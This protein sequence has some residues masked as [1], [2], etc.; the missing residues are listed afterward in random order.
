MGTSRFSR[1]PCC[2]D[3]KKFFKVIGSHS[4]FVMFS[5][6]AIKHRWLC[7]NT[8][9]V[10]QAKPLAM[11]LPLSAKTGMTHVAHWYIPCFDRS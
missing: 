4:E 1:W 3:W 10:W 11:W 5:L 6:Q 7:D 8:D 2:R 9:R